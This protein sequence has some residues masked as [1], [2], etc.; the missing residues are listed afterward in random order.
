MSLSRFS[1]NSDLYVCRQSDGTFLVMVAAVR[2]PALSRARA[3]AMELDEYMDWIRDAGKKIGGPRDGD[4][5]EH[6]SAEALVEDLRALEKSGY[7]VPAALYDQL[8]DLLPAQ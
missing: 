8:T 1:D 5:F 2:F 7:R 4:Y 6:A 3:D